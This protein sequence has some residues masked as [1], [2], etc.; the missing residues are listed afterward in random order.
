MIDIFFFF[1][2]KIKK[3]IKKMKLTLNIFIATIVLLL[4]THYVY[5]IFYTSLST[6]KLGKCNFGEWSHPELDTAPVDDTFK[7]RPFLIE[8]KA[9]PIVGQFS[10][11]IVLTSIH[12]ITPSVRH[13]L[14][15]EQYVILVVADIASPESYG[16]EHDRLIYLTVEWQLRLNYHITEFIPYSSYT[17]KNIGYLFAIK[18]GAQYIFDTDDDNALARA[19][20]PWTHD[21]SSLIPC[22]RLRDQ[23]AVNPYAAFGAPHIWPRGFPIESIHAECTGRGSVRNGSN[24]NGDNGWIQQ[25]LADLDPDIDAIYRLTH[26]EELGHIIFQ[27]RYP[28]YI[29]PN[30]MAP[31]NSQNTLFDKRAFWG[32]FLPTSVS[33]RLTDIWR[34]YYVQRLMWMVGGV[35]AFVGPTVQQHRNTHSFKHD[36][37]EEL[38][39]YQQTGQLLRFL[40]AW[41]PSLT[42]LRD[43]GFF[44]AMYDLAE[45]MVIAGFWNTSELNV[46]DA[47][48]SDLY[49]A[50][51]PPPMLTLNPQ[52]VTSN[53]ETMLNYAM[54]YSKMVVEEESNPMAMCASAFKDEQYNQ[55]V[56]NKV[57]GWMSSFWTESASRAVPI[58]SNTDGRGIG[59]QIYDLLWLSAFVL[60]YNR[61]FVFA[62]NDFSIYNT[63]TIC[64]H[65]YGGF[66]CLFD[67]PAVNTSFPQL[68]AKIDK[69]NHVP[70]QHVMDVDDV[71]LSINH[72]IRNRIRDDLWGSFVQHGSILPTVMQQHGW[73]SFEWFAFIIG[74]ITEPSSKL[75]FLVAQKKQ[76]LDWD[77]QCV[78]VHIRRADKIIEIHDHTYRP[79]QEYIDEISRL[80]IEHP[81]LNVVFVTS[82]N[83]SAIEQFESLLSVRHPSMRL[84]VDRA[85]VRYNGKEC[86]S[87]NEND[88][89][90]RCAHRNALPVGEKNDWALQT[91]MDYYLLSSC[92]FLIGSIG[93]FFTR[94]A[95]GRLVS[96]YLHEPFAEH[97]IR[98]IGDFDSLNYFTQQD[99]NT[100]SI[101][102]L[103]EYFEK[104]R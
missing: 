95:A 24:L 20:S 104:H 42:R 59:G 103:E 96:R 58:L 73:T 60:K 6:K 32:L 16:I 81:H 101:P 76:Q 31:F 56:L 83:S 41:K 46:I 39:M 77:P 65:A 85:Q 90:K 53:R 23:I 62:T 82:D 13:F 67:F 55:L 75:K 18:H 79:T 12:E 93:S 34:G 35:V 27:R 26:V 28:I 88:A 48:I 2:K 3:K 43:H 69:T 100:F 70:L 25:G 17:R 52:D 47:W 44:G 68:L 38:Q 49:E 15:F 22:A 102:S 9:L 30:F 14:D 87:F 45:D 94:I 5:L 1:E 57:N 10:H 74:K 91:M 37:E 98:P 72:N 71:A 63:V 11:W 54:F 66:T 4:F 7:K 21:M 92:D 78:S 89:N 8:D 33:F 50:G 40:T 51:Y 80:R 99:N 97:R 84:V 64:D 61:P 86:Q 19:P 29:P 36:F